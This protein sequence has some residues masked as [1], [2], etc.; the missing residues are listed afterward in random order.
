M[1]RS[2]TNNNEPTVAAA[3]VVEGDVVAADADVVVDIDGAASFNN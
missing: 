1:V 3:V 2:S